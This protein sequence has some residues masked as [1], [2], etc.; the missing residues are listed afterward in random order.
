[1]DKADEM[2]GFGKGEGRERLGAT[3]HNDG[4]LELGRANGN[5]GDLVLDDKCLNDIIISTTFFNND[6]NNMKCYL[7]TKSAD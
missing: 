7:R 2:D 5:E 4:D 1:M 3:I 6:N